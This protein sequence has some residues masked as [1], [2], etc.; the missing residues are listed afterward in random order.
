LR[1]RLCGTKPGLMKASCV[2]Y[3]GGSGTGNEAVRLHREGKF[4][5]VRSGASF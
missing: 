2:E 4:G 3:S 5:A 1:R